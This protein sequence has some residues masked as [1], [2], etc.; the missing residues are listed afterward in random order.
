VPDGVVLRP[1]TLRDADAA[2]TLHMTCWRE[3][4]GPLV[5][6]DLLATELADPASW[7]RKWRERIAL[8]APRLLAS[9]GP[10]LLGFASVGA[11]RHDE[12][13]VETE[14]YA[15]YVL[16]A[17]HGTGIA[18][19][20]LDVSLG[21]RSAYLWVLEDNVRARRFYERNGFRPQGARKKFA[22]LD[23]WELMLV[24]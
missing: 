3:A 19:A 12:A 17:W 13:P 23:A 14:L 6:A 21:D 22:P 8:G 2:A 9:K 20:L 10:D 7:A 4:Y 18:Q 15:I 24:R 16:A 11:A 1:A 5:D